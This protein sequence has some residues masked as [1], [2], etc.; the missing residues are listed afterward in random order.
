MGSPEMRVDTGPESLLDH[1]LNFSNTKHN[2]LRCSSQ[3]VVGTQQGAE[4]SPECGE[5]PGTTGHDSV[6]E[7]AGA[8]RY[9]Q[10]YRWNV[11]WQFKD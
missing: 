7:H 3:K 11:G 1:G 10:R 5:F 6:D 2:P 9:G 8:R 4:L